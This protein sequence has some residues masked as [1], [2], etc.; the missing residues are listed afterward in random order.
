MSEGLVAGDVERQAEDAVIAA[1]EADPTIQAFFQGAETA[2]ARIDR[3]RKKKTRI[4]PAVSVRFDAEQSLPRTNEY[5]LRGAITCVT[6][7][8]D[9]TDSATVQRLVGAV[10]DAL[11][12]DSTPSYPDHF[13]GDCEGF[14]EQLN[15]IADR[16]V[17]HQIHEG[18]TT[19]ESE[20]RNRRRVMALDLFGYPGRTGNN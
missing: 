5:H 1:L 4:L 12:K 15:K 8:D 2:A 6:A 9:D 13:A 16:M 18:E 7:V 17:F 20:G 3:E 10:R 19:P 14:L 11:H